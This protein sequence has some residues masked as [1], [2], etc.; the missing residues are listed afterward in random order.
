[1][2]MNDRITNARKFI[3]IY[4]EI[5][6]YMRR[7]QKVDNRV[8]HTQLIKDMGRQ[9]K[10]FRNHCDDLI[11]FAELRNAIVHNPKNRDANPIAEPH[12]NIVKLYQ[13]LLDKVTKPPLAL[14]TVAIR[15][16]DIYKTSLENNALEVIQEMNKHTY[17]HV[18]VLEDDKIIGVFSENTVFSYF[19][20]N[21]EVLLDKDALIKEFLDFIPFD[22]HESEYF[23]FVSKNTLLI[24]VEDIF[25]EGLKDNKRIA[26]VFITET[27]SEK[28]KLLGLITAWDLVGY[29]K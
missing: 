12:D 25:R 27:G 8:S 26:T 29:E 5:D 1:M 7:F 20:S 28:E 9:N 16:N 22:K 17:T 15:A 23:E 24:D 2:E 21:E 10:L 19:A 14:N 3:A 4:N 11:S 6:N 18:P 13:D